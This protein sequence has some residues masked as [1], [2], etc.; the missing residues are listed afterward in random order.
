MMTTTVMTETQTNIVAD[1]TKTATTT[2]EPTTQPVQ[3]A[4]FGVVRA[5]GIS[6]QELE[7]LQL[8]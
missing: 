4:P 3:I 6:S 8:S 7:P 5:G 2:P 1:N